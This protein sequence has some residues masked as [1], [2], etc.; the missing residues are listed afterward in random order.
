MVCNTKL[1]SG[2]CYMQVNPD[3]CTLYVM[4]NLTYCWPW[5]LYV[6]L[7]PSQFLSSTP[8]KNIIWQIS[9]TDNHLFLTPLSTTHLCTHPLPPNLTSTVHSHPPL[10]PVHHHPSKTLTPARDWACLWSRT[11]AWHLMTVL[12][13]PSNLQRSPHIPSHSKGSPIANNSFAALLSRFW[14][15]QKPQ[16]MV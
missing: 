9:P 12:M 11:Q 5:P 8:S 4:T 10:L 2:V 3:R 7:Y 14:D 6:V 1:Q 13:I 16:K 15:M